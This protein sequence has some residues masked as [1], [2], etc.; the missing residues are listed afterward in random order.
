MN[1]MVKLWWLLLLSQR[2]TTVVKK[3]TGGGGYRILV[4]GAPEMLM[5]HCTYALTNNTDNNNN[6]NKDPIIEPLTDYMKV[7]ILGRVTD[8]ASMG[9]RTILAGYRDVTDMPGDLPVEEIEK[10]LILVTVFGIEDP[11]RPEVPEAIEV[12]LG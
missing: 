5:P 12:G 8:Y 1:N 4:K 10:D 11:V 6:N 7:E 2:M 3:T 9:L